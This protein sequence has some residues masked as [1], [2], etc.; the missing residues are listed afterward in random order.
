VRAALVLAIMP[1]L[2]GLILSRPYFGA[3]LFIFTTFIRPQNL[4]WGFEEVRFALVVSLATAVGFFLKRR[5][6]RPAGGATAIPWLW[7]LMAAMLVSTLTARVSVDTSL[8]WNDKFFKIAIFSTLLTFL[9]DRRERIDRTFFWYCAGMG[10]LALWAFEQHFQGNERLEGIGNGGDIDHS[11]G[12]ACAFVMALPLTIAAGINTPKTQRVRRWGLLGLAP[13]FCLDVVFT[14]S[15]AGYLALG[16]AGLVAMR[17]RKLRWKVAAVML[18]GG[19]AFF[20]S[21]YVKRAETIVEQGR[22]LDRSQD[23][24]IATR[25]VLWEM[26]LDMWTESPVTGVGQQNSALLVKQTQIGRAKSIHNT[27]L[28]ILADG[29]ALAFM[30]YAGAVIAGLSDLRRARRDALRRNDREVWNWTVAV[31][32]S[33]AAFAASGTFNSFDYLEMPY[34]LLA[35]SGTIRAVTAR[36]AGEVPV[37]RGAEAVPLAA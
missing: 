26:A 23:G 18:V 28:Q 25:V 13:I 17:H 6:F 12:I 14:Q 19:L 24:S 15:R 37:V 16:T 5:S 9:V 7:A 1:F 11:N 8:F 22:G 4:T 30:A 34:W 21:K 3:C 10:A 27:W 33:L 20:S 2:V 29:G 35:L 31:E 32:C 36:E